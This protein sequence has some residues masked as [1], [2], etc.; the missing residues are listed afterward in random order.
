MS[1]QESKVSRRPKPKTGGYESIAQ[2]WFRVP[3]GLPDFTFYTVQAMMLDPTV[4]LGMAMRRAFIQSIRIAYK[5][6]GQSTGSKPQWVDGVRA[7]SDEVAAYVMR[8]FNKLW[9]L[10]FSKM[11]QAQVWGWAG[12]EV[13]W[14]YNPRTNTIDI[15]DVLDRHALDIRAYV[16]NGRPVGVRFMRVKQANGYVDLPFPYCLFHSYFPDA[17][18]TYGWSALL[19]AY[20]PWADKNL[21]GAALDV[22]RVFMHKD[23]YGGADMTYPEGTTEVDGLDIPNRDIARQIVEQLK[24]GGVTTRPYD[25]DLQG[26]SKWQL[27]RATVPSNPAHILQYPKDLDVEILRGL[28]IPDDVL[29]ADNSGAWEGKKVPMTTFLSNLDLWASSML[30]DFKTQ[31]LDMGVKWSFGRDA[32]FE[33]DHVP[34]VE[35]VM[36]SMDNAD[37]QKEDSQQQPPQQQTPPENPQNAMA[38]SLMRRALKVARVIN[39]AAMRAPKGGV[40]I[41]GTFYPGGQGIPSAVIDSASEEDKAKLQPIS[42]GGG[43]NDTADTKNVAAATDGSEGNKGNGT[44]TGLRTGLS[45]GKFQNQLFAANFEKKLTDEQLLA[46]MQKEFPTRAKFQDVNKV[47]YYFNKG[48]FGLGP[49][50]GGVELPPFDANG[51]PMTKRR[52]AK[53]LPPPLPPPTEVPPAPKRAPDAVDRTSGTVVDTKSKSKYR[54]SKEE[55]TKIN[56]DIANA[57]TYT[58]IVTAVR[59]HPALRHVFFDKKAFYDN[60]NLKSIMT[61]LVMAING[62][63]YLPAFNWFTAVDKAPSK[64]MESAMAWASPVPGQGK[65]TLNLDKVGKPLRLVNSMRACAKSGW[66]ANS[67]RFRPHDYDYES[68]LTDILTH[69]LGHIWELPNKYFKEQLVDKGIPTHNYTYKYDAELSRQTEFL[70]LAV[71]S[72]NQASWLSEY[73]TT[74]RVEI[75]SEFM[76]MTTRFPVEHLASN[77]GYVKAYNEWA[78]LL[79]GRD[80]LPEWAQFS[81][82]QLP[83]KVRSNA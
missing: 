59:Q 75:A 72:K 73:S 21:D 44:T 18:C 11:A 52:K 42:G 16:R 26:K 77:A 49:P 50:A 39:M 35:Q 43:K 74:S 37:T 38:M 70:R 56:D 28:E 9:S 8:N 47:R 32:W 48:L 40:T 58:D 25:P 15:D 14:G 22:R 51:Q 29:S 3:R 33:L 63:G 64:D 17:G 81:E 45:I 68:A 30:R 80:K 41:N 79:G 57:D 19:G 66:L 31:C 1:R 83:T 71:R 5:T 46:E 6:T 24:A 13:V 62:I 36:A 34:L 4:R 61:S 76:T 82:D 23:A 54:L 67:A 7:S 12:A 69:E 2:Y 10:G 53:P 65:I 55:L 78:E 20:S 27:E 60:P